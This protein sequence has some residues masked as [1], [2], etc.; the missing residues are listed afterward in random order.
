MADH[1]VLM[2]QTNSDIYHTRVTHG[3]ALAWANSY[4]AVVVK[5]PEATLLF[6][7]VSME[8]PEDATLDLIAVSHSHSD[9]WDPSAVVKMQRQS[10]ALVATSQSL[11]H[12]LNGAFQNQGDTTTVVAVQPGDTLNF[13]DATITIL[14]CDHAA[15]EPLSFLVQTADGVTIYLP[16]DTTPFPEMERVP[17][18][19]LSTVPPPEGERDRVRIDILL[20]MGTALEDGARIA[21]Q[22]KPKEFLTYAIAPSAAGARARDILTR[23]TPSLPFRA[24]ERHEV[25][26]YS[27]VRR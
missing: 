2:Q 14:R 25:F 7:P 20:W 10:R 4:S 6:D 15:V 8:L 16:G 17:S 9:H 12:R 1:P 22:V 19:S 5:T 27:G 13:G 23:Y 21:Q 24:L 18:P 26:L 11:A 3:V